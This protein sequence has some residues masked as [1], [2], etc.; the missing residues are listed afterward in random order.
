MSGSSKLTN[1]PWRSGITGRKRSIKRLWKPMEKMPRI[2]IGIGNPGPEYDNIRHNVGRNFTQ[3]FT[4]KMNLNFQ[5]NTEM[6]NNYDC[7]MCY[8]QDAK[9]LILKPMRFMNM[10]GPVLAQILND[11]NLNI[12]DCCVAYDC[13]YTKFGHWQLRNNSKRSR[14]EIIFNG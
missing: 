1:F 4:N 5:M 14:Y 2:L 11:F 6:N 7:E 3:F 12:D 13:F 9:L 8:F 10:Y